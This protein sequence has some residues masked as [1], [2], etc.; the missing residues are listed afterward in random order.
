MTQEERVIIGL[1]E[2]IQT[3][4]NSILSKSNKKYN[5]GIIVE[6]ITGCNIESEKGL[7]PFIS[8]HKLEEENKTKDRIIDTTSYRVNLTIHEKESIHDSWRI[9]ARYVEA[10]QELVNTNMVN[11]GVWEFASVKGCKN[12][13][14]EIEIIV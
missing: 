3:E 14:I 10:V 4:Y 11:E 6:E 2:L 13:V 1:H 9:R 12:N 8:I 5:D 7:R